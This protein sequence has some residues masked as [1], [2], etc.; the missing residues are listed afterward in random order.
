MGPR[1]RVGLSLSMMM[2]SI[3][4]A[5]CSL[6]V[7]GEASLESQGA[8]PPSPASQPPPS[9]TGWFY[10]VSQ[11]EGYVTV[12][13]G[14]NFQRV[15]RIDLWAYEWER[16]FPPGEPRDPSVLEAIQREA[17]PFEV[18]AVPGAS[19]LYVTNRSP[20]GDR[21]WVID[22]N[23]HTVQRAIATGTPAPH[24]LAFSPTQPLAA[25][26]HLYASPGVVTFLDTRIHRVVGR[27][28]TT[29]TRTRDVIFSRD[30]RYLFV[31]QQ[32][33]ARSTGN[34]GGVDVLDVQAQRIVETIPVTGSR[35]MALS[36]DGRTLAVASFAEGWVGLVDT[37][38]WDLFARV[39]VGGRPGACSF[40][41]DGRKLYVGVFRNPA[42]GTGDEFVVVDVAS[43]SVRTRI[44]AGRQPGR[45]FFPPGRPETAL[46]VNER[47]TRVMVLD[48]RRDTV[49]KVIEVPLGGYA[50]D[51]TPDGRFALLTCRRSREAVILDLESLR[52]HHVIA[53]AGYGNGGVRWISPPR[54]LEQQSRRIAKGGAAGAFL[55]EKRRSP[56]VQHRGGATVAAGG[57][58]WR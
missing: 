55:E 24:R 26:S 50:M 52:V 21:L 29:G 41:P 56:W 13:N 6:P 45:V 39:D 54:S 25:V 12:L 20:H 28:Q 15:H 19:V 36:P 8:A 10:V 4:N 40:S 33:Y 2:L 58:S 35:A 14:R 5:A 53:E 18:W 46:G 34:L 27:V 9:L 57:V 38:T 16:A 7:T 48:T 51:F 3:A 11:R 44:Q 30:G 47:D 23:T 17:R 22:P 42:T 37:E 1:V 49:T 31:S 43:R 32:G